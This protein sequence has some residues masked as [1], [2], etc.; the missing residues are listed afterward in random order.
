MKK[1]LIL[2]L[3]VFILMILSVFS[4]SAAE[5][6][7]ILKGVT[8]ELTENKADGKFY[9]VRSFFDYEHKDITE[10]IIIAEKINDIPVLSVDVRFDKEVPNEENYSVKKI[11]L[12]EGLKYIED[13]ALS[14]F[15]GVKSI[16]LPSTLVRIDF[17][18]MSGMDS[19]K[20]IT[21][22]KSLTKV[23]EKAF[24]GCE[25]LS[26]VVFKGKVT[27]I[28][29]NAFAYCTS[30]K[31]ITLPDSLKKLGA[32]AFR[33]SGLVSVT[34]PEKTDVASPEIFRDCKKL[35]KVIFDGCKRKKGLEL[36]TRMFYGCTSLKSVSL[37]KESK[38]IKIGYEAFRGCKAFTSFTVIS[39]VSKI[40]EKAFYG[41]TKL[42]KV[43]FE[44]S[45]TVP[46]IGKKAFV[47]TA[48][49]IK[50]VAENKKTATALK[51]KIKA[52][53]IK[54]PTVGYVKYVK[55]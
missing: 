18:G 43:T 37:P 11:I 13:Y 32:G 39:E 7:V 30:L 27:S 9:R 51:K 2:T 1:K 6:T 26:K 23:G 45:K 54:K 31:K 15:K 52:T 49:E 40:G 36:G 38:E 46:A 14:N 53:G 29:S 19:L 20:S 48:K 47:K 25:S 33:G 22:P 44:N 24:D 21:L 8:Y 17:G 28:G 50:F 12:P 5:K 10:E 34:V 16:S 42:K 35:K 41:C 3:T 55:V 4:V